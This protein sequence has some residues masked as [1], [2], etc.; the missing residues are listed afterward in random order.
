[1]SKLRGVPYETKF[2]AERNAYPA[3]KQ[4][5]KVYFFEDYDIISED[6]DEI[7]EVFK[8]ESGEEGIRGLP[9]DIHRFLNVYGATDEDLSAAFTRIFRP[10]MAIYGWNGRTLRE[11]LNKIV[12][13]MSDPANLGR[14][15]P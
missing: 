9:D 11:A 15:R 14:P 2:P 10:Q 8:H 12:E 13:I 5:V 7:V 3:L 1:M 4:L 6:P